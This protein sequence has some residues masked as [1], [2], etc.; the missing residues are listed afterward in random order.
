MLLTREKNIFSVVEY[1]DEQGD[2]RSAVF[3][4]S[5]S[6]TGGVSFEFLNADEESTEELVSWNYSYTKQDRSDLAVEARVFR[7]M[8]GQYRYDSVLSGQVAR[9][10]RAEIIAQEESTE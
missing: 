2:K 8:D 9:Q 6:E 3:P 10:K 5:E 1:I 4:R 7:F